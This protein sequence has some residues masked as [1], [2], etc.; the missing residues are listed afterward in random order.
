MIEAKKVGFN[1]SK[2]GSVIDAYTE[3]LPDRRQLSSYFAAL[4]NKHGNSLKYGILTD[5]LYFYFY[6][7]KENSSFLE[8]YPFYSFYIED[9]IFGKSKVDCLLWYLFSRHFGT[10][11]LDFFSVAAE[12]A[13]AF[14]KGIKK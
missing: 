14:K 11:M 1:I 3:E 7:K 12:K 5:G 9:V 13:M 10:S 4:Q 8:E 6:K 2:S